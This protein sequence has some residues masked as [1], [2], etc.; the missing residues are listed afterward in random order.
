MEFIKKNENEKEFWKHWEIFVSEQSPGPRY[1]KS[2]IENFLEMSKSRDWLKGDQSL[3]LVQ[4]N[5]PVG[6]VFLPIEEK[7]GV[8]SVSF[9]GRHTMAPLFSEDHVRKE[10]FRYVDEV[11]DKEY[12]QKIMFGV[13][14]LL[15]KQYPYNFLLAHGYLNTSLLSYVIDLS[16]SLD[17]LKECRRGHRSDIKTALHDPDFERFAVD[18]EHPNHAFHEEYRELHRIDAGRVTRSKASFDSQYQKLTDGNAVL[19]G[20]RYRGSVIAYAY[21]E[22]FQDKAIYASAASHPA[23]THL[24]LYHL[25]MW[26]AMEY[27]Q[28]KG[29][30]SIE[31]G[32]PVNPSVQFGYDIDDKIVNIS[33]FK[34]GFGGS[35]VNEF[36]GIKYRDAQ[37][38]SREAN[39]FQKS[40]AAEI[41][42]KSK[43]THVQEPA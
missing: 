1:V 6:A 4:N 42:L 29:V 34:R 25:L 5:K 12:V 15:N 27:F 11:A 22:M 21:Y 16:P 14:P 31:V 30:H 36:R 39:E 41:D 9:C 23:M 38:F 24:P 37:L 8:C 2:A 3:V 19:F 35:F 7:D 18:R 20:L 10:L 40:Y 33:R 32:Q 13:D 28:T 43:N 26:S 17:L